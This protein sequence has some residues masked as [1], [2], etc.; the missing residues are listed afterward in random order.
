M[1]KNKIKKAD[2]NPDDVAVFSFG[3]GHVIVVDEKPEVRTL[4]GSSE[5]LMFRRPSTIRLWGTRNGL[6]Q[7]MSTGP[8]PDTT[9]DAVPA[10]LGIPMAS[11]HGVWLCSAAAA[12]KLAEEIQQAEL[13][14]LKGK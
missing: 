6:G 2:V 13:R 9:L 3:R 7:L 14:L 1:S 5:W 4:Y 10:G 12:P 11:I 8:T